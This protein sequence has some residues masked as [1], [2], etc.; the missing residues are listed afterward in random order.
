MGRD[1][2]GV[3]AVLVRVLV[4][5]RHRQADVAEFQIRTTLVLQ[6]D[7]PQQG[8]VLGIHII[9]GLHIEALHG[10]VRRGAQVL[11]DEVDL[12]LLVADNGLL[13]IGVIG[14][15]VGCGGRAAG[16]EGLVRVDLDKAG[17]VG[18]EAAVRAGADGEDHFAHP[19]ML[20]TVLGTGVIG[21]DEVDL[22]IASISGII[23]DV[24]RRNLSEITDRDLQTVIC[25]FVRCSLRRHAE[26]RQDAGEQGRDHDDGQHDRDHTSGQVVH[27]LHEMFSPFRFYSPF[28]F[29]RKC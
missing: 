10:T 21:E 16:C 15:D 26:A 14:S 6:G 19:L 22:T 29:R 17:V 20:H 23:H 28:E 5:P 27:S 24:E 18:G 3:D 11:A 8:A 4:V 13:D 12:D 7:G 9:G 2:L 1:A 25:N